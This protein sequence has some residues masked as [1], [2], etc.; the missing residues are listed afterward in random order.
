MIR[1]SNDTLPPLWGAALRLLLA[2]FLLFCF[3]AVTKTVLPRGPGL[4]AAVGYGVLNFGISLGLLYWGE[5]LI[6]SGLAAVLYPTAPVFS[7]LLPRAFGLEKLNA[8][9]LVA[10]VVAL[11]GVVLISWR[12][13][14][15]GKSPAAIAAVIASV[16]TA[17]C[18]N[19][20][21]KRGPK[22]SA[23]ATNAVATLVGGPS[24]LVGSFLF[25]EKHPLPLQPSQFLPL[26]Y[27]TLA[28]SIGAFVTMT[29]LLGRWNASS[30][31]FIA[32]VIPVIAVAL[33]AIFR[34]ES[35]APG[36][37]V[38]VAVVLVATAFV[39]RSEAGAH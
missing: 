27:L 6:P 23:I 1:F 7:M 10:A 33:G 4:K 36:S 3:C 8:G 39:L 35:L 38:G 34:G 24:C 26:L 11:G 9:K 2:S 13:I 5:T 28:G 30:T 31:S 14:Q 25:Q 16:V 18:S 15:V 20:V 22:Q 19:M 32:V 17:I 21:L 29:W 37:F 12:E